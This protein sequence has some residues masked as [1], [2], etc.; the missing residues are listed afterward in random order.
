MTIAVCPA[1]DSAAI[2]DFHHA[3]GVPTNS[4]L[5]LEDELQARTFPKARLDLAVCHGCGFIMNRAFDADRAEYSARYEETQAF[6][7]T[8]VDFGRGLAKTWVDDHDLHGTHVLEIG[9]GKG[10]FLTWMIEAG[11]GT[12]TGID[13]G[14]HPERLEGDAAAQIEWIADFY[15][16]RHAHLTAD[17]IVCRHTLEH[18]Q[19]VGD[20]LRT[21]RA[22]IGDRTDTIV[23]F[24]LPDT[25]RVLREAAFWDVYYEH[26]S[27][28][29]LDSLERLFSNC[30]F[31]VVA[32]SYAYDDQYLLIEAVPASSSAPHTKASDDQR[33]HV[34]AL[35]R[36]FG[37]AVTE[38]ITGWEARLRGVRADGGRVALWGGGSKAVAFLT[39]L[40]DPSLVDAV[41]DINP[42]KQGRYIAGTGHVVLSPGGL[43]EVAPE[44]VVAM[45]PVYVHDIRRELDARG[46][47]GS[48][49]MAV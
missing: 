46:L 20:F 30:G 21:I 19:P 35:A 11:V 8:F 25:L 14:V 42:H 10:E 2:E 24:E 5:L 18:I 41:V 29:T 6:S 48:R 4:C 17:A 12:G 45:N 31:H 15:D 43:V 47:T 27:Y 1:C 39:S 13:P 26:C 32:R 28:F 33:D 40:Q 22:N 16:E 7:P 9:C 34:V 49:L 37:L 36:Q 44:L 23:L 3:K 38:L